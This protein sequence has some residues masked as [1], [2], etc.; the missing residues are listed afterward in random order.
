MRFDEIRMK[1]QLPVQIPV[2]CL[3]CLNL[4]Y[5]AKILELTMKLRGN[6][7]TRLEILFTAKT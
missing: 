1:F 3:I 6:L 4:K 7:T 5:L 2:D